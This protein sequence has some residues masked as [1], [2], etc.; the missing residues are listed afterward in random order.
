MPIGK[1]TFPVSPKSDWKY[2]P[3]QDNQRK[4]DVLNQMDGDKMEYYCPI[5]G[6]RG[7]TYEIDEKG[8]LV[9]RECSCDT[10]RKNLRRMNAS[11]LHRILEEDLF[12]SFHAKESWQQQILEKAKAYAE[13]PHGWFLI[14]GQSGC[15]KTHLCTAIYRE[16]LLAGESV[17]YMSWR[18]EITQL[19][20]FSDTAQRNQQIQKWKEV[21]V[22]YMDDLF[23]TGAGSDGRARPTSADI[24]V[25]YE[26]LN[27][28]YLNQL[29]AILS[30][31]FS[32]EELIQLDEALAGR[33]VQ[34]AVDNII[35]IK[36]DPH[37]N[38]RL[39][40]ILEL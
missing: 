19:K 14:C 27:Y 15:G 12:D 1:M 16:R 8:Y 7:D 33:I 17:L 3:T 37:K 5:C 40:K 21:S 2:D 20:M 26:V 4:A 13:N 38:F 11:G 18:E 30:T 29:D 22:L 25:T 36:T 6:H 28:R 24:N 31:E 39:N 23:K 35:V 9:F 32:L 34:R 10:I